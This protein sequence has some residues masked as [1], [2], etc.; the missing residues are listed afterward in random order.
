[1]E[2]EGIVLNGSIVVNTPQ[3]LLEGTKVKVIVPAAPSAGAGPSLRDFL[4][5]I[6][7]TVP[8]W[9]AD[10]ASNHDH[11]L[12]GAPKRSEEARHE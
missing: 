10:M 11:Y 12:H 6:A 8:E 1:V 5:S 7:G 2:L 4:L 9:P 3:P